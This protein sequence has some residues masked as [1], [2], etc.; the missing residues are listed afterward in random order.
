MD[1][2][3]QIQ[4]PL[5]PRRAEDDFRA[6]GALGVLLHTLPSRKKMTDLTRQSGYHLFEGH[7]SILGLGKLHVCIVP[8]YRNRYVLLHP[9]PVFLVPAS[10]FAQNKIVLVSTP[11]CVLISLEIGPMAPENHFSWL[12]PVRK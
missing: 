3:H 6:L 5:N 2:L 10:C 4:G 8:S 1:T 11:I 9:E 12:L 7:K